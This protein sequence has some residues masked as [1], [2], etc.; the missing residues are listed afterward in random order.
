MKETDFIE[1][2]NTINNIEKFVDNAN[3][4]GIDIS[5]SIIFSYG[6]LADKV[7]QAYYIE[8]GVDL[9]NWYLY[10]RNIGLDSTQN[11]LDDLSELW[12]NLEKNYRKNV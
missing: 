7:W 11:S 6:I 1:C 4:I 8:E 5:N 2:V 9:I 10:D 12:E 3:K